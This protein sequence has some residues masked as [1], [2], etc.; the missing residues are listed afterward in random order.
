MQVTQ[1][2]I[3]LHSHTVCII[4]LRLT[5]L[6]KNTTI[7]LHL[8]NVKKYCRFIMY[9]IL[10]T[11]FMHFSL[12]TLVSLC[13]QALSAVLPT[14]GP[15]SPI[16]PRHASRGEMASALQHDIGLTQDNACSWER[17]LTK[18]TSAATRRPNYM[19]PTHRVTCT[20]RP[21]LPRD[22]ERAATRLRTT[23]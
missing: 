16:S 7:A 17:G 11:R 3:C 4:F 8:F 21:R 2:T 13:S 14:A 9:D 22:A 5:C 12:C 1:T 10:L 18:L 20:Q 6:C 15:A 23:S 19:W